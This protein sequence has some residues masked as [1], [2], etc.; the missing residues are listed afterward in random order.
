MFSFPVKSGMFIL[1]HCL[2]LS[3]MGL[4]AGLSSLFQPSLE[5][6][7]PVCKENM[8]AYSLLGCSCNSKQSGILKLFV[9]SGYGRAFLLTCVLVFIVCG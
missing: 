3:E 2:S 1:L 4:V 5:K 9:T 8:L 7:A 6:Q